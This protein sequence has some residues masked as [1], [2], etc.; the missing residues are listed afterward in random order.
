VGRFR[1]PYKA[2]IT[3]TDVGLLTDTGVLNEAKMNDR[4]KLT[5]R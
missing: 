3:V 5:V 2:A 1:V 4:V